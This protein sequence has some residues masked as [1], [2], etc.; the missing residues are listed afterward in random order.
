MNNKNKN[1]VSKILIGLNKLLKV[2]LNNNICF[3]AYI[4]NL[5]IRK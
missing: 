2:I 4:S 5:I 3:K 1:S